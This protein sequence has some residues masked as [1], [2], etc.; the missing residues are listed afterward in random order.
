MESSDDSTSVR[1][2][3]RIR[4]QLPKERIDMC[5]VCTSVTPGV[6]QVFLG[7]DKAFTFDYVYDM[8]NNQRQIY[9]SCANA[10]IEGTFDGYNA[11]IFA[12]GQT[13]SG[14]TY[15]MGTG[16]GLG[17]ME[18]EIG[19]VPRAVE[20]LFNGI[21]ARR[22]A[23]I[24]KGEP[25]PEFKVLAQ[26][27]EIYYEEI[28]DL[29]DTTRDASDKLGSQSAGRSVARQS[30]R[31]TV[32]R[33]NQGPSPP[34]PWAISFTPLCLSFGR[35]TT[36]R[37]YREPHTPGSATAVGQPWAVGQPRQWVSHGCGSAM[38]V[39]QPRLL[40][41]HGSGSA[42]AVG[43]PRQWVSHGSGSATA[44]GQPRLWVSHGSGSASAVGQP[45]QS[46]S[47]DSRSATAVGQPRQSVSHGSRSAMAEG[48]PWQWVSQGC[49][50]A[51]A[52]GQPRLWAVWS[53]ENREMVFS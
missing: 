6:P 39:G 17:I 38:A 51:K 5:Q 25:P 49:G 29:L 3:L 13:G 15:T 33:Q 4:P 47:H 43:Q 19:I 9:E 7:K 18:E 10:L 23:A 46:V 52:V 21:E 40:V 16:F 53:L 35:D 1:V 11:T 50:S 30:Q 41:S 44:V 32:S 8:E 14:K 2:A 31:W 20:H 22:K 36:G 42:T 28:L 34:L 24:E 48:Q 37:N 27:M 12:Y 26:F 45:R